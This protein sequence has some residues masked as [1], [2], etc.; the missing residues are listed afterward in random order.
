MPFWASW[1]CY[2]LLH[3]DTGSTSFECAPAACYLFGYPGLKKSKVGIYSILKAVGWL[4]WQ[5][6][7]LALRLLASK[8]N[9]IEKQQ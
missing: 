3:T 5:E 1:L 9:N 2:A 6:W 7:L 8:K 4:K